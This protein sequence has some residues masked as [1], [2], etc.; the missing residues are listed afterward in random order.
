MK[1]K[2]ACCQMQ[3]GLGTKAENIAKMKGMLAD[4]M[5]SDK[6]DLVVFPEL[7]STGY[8]CSEMYGELAEEYEGSETVAIFAEEAKKYGVHIVFGMVEKDGDDVYNTAVIIDD[9]GTPLGKYQ[10]IHLVDGEETKYFKKGTEYPVF[11][12]K[13]GKIGMMICWDM[14]YPEAARCLALGGAEIIVIPSAWETEPYYGDWDL[15]N[16]ARSLDNI[17]YTASC[18][19][20]GLDRELDFIGRSMICGPVGRT[21]VQAGTEDEIIVAEVDLG[22]LPELREGYYV[23]LNDRN[24]STY[25]ALVK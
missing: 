23:L 7:A 1:T 3:S 2:I 25:G 9:N 8:E 21:I 19:H 14:A 10:K 11:D 20:V 6:P 22:V 16:Q 24:P 12:T 18:N 15:F 4:V 5:A 17:C 13:I